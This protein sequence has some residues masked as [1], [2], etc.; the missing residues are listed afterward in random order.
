MRGGAA[1]VT[2]RVTSSGDGLPMPHGS[3][4]RSSASSSAFASIERHLEVDAQLGHEIVLGELSTRDLV[5]AR[6]ELRDAIAPRS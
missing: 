1:T 4:C 5:E 2:P 3:R 6:R